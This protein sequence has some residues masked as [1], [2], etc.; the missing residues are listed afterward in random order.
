M[1]VE[2]DL[3]GEVRDAQAPHIVTD[4]RNGDDERN[5]PRPVVLDEG[6]IGR[7][8]QRASGSSSFRK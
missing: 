1:W 2:I 6:E 5:E 3:T 8:D 7:A 4:H